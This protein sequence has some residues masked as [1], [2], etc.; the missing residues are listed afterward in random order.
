[1]KLVVFGTL[2]FLLVLSST[3]VLSK[4]SK[5]HEKADLLLDVAETMADVYNFLQF[6]ELLYRDPA[7]ACFVLALALV[8]AGV[9]I[10]CGCEDVCRSKSARKAYVGAT[11]ASFLLRD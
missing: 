5:D 9:I 4:P 2:L 3:A 1:M 11:G 6:M 10:C 8:L 7:Q